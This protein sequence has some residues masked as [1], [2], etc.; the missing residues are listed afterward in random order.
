MKIKQSYEMNTTKAYAFSWEQCAKGI[1]S[2]IESTSNF[3]IKIY[4]RPNQIVKM[5][6]QKALNYQEH[7]Y[8]IAI[9]L[10]LFCTLIGLKQK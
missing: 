7:C 3:D 5:I 9:M 6:N 10:D 2:K 4:R 1:Q 8:K